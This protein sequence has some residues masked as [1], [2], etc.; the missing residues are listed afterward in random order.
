MEEEILNEGTETD[1]SKKNKKKKKKSHHR[2]DQ[3]SSSLNND[4]SCGSNICKGIC[5][6]F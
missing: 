6:I 5:V 4:R 2:R 3:S 1:N